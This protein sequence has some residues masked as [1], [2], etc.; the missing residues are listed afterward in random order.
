MSCVLAAGSTSVSIS[1]RN[2]RFGGWAMVSFSGVATKL[3]AGS[4]LPSSASETSLSSSP[5]STSGAGA[6]SV[7]GLSMSVA[8]TVE[9]VG[10]SD[11]SRFD[12]LDQPVGRAVILEANEAGFFGAHGLL[13]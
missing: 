6:P 9:A 12:G 3:S 8:R 1:S 5:S 11:T 4:G 2:G 13:I 7:L 10:C